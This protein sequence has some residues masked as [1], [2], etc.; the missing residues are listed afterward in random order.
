VEKNCTSKTELGKNAPR[1]ISLLSKIPLHA[2]MNDN[3]AVAVISLVDVV[4]FLI[5]F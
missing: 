4:L 5:S 2:A 3:L 1:L